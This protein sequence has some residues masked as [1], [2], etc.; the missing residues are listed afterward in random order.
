MWD[1]YEGKT[2]LKVKTD[3]H[4]KGFED[5]HAAAEYVKDFIPEVE[6][7]EEKTESTP[8]IEFSDGTEEEKKED[9]PTEPT[10]EVFMEGVFNAITE[11]QETL[12]DS[13]T[14][15]NG[16]LNYVIA[17]SD[18][19][20]AAETINQ[21]LKK[22]NELEARK[23]EI[24]E[25]SWGLDQEIAK[26]KAENDTL[27][28]Q[29]KEYVANDQRVSQQNGIY[30]QEIKKLQD[31]IATRNDEY[32]DL[33]KKFN[34]KENDEVSAQVIADE[35]AEKIKDLKAKIEDLEKQ[36]SIPRKKVIPI[37]GLRDLPL[38]GDKMLRGL[39]PFL[40]RYNI[41]VDHNK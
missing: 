24:L 38:V 1:A 21:L 26:L 29:N 32:E 20:K 17:T 5:I 4:Y 13:S 39:I 22:I 11:L 36:L 2:A 31:L 6:K 8:L 35:R 16:V 41:Y 3:K 15:L 25:E 33:K 12:K 34:D 9:Q 7:E 30:K 18:Q 37:S 19:A 27:K 40:D 28:T 14:K 10:S 23:K